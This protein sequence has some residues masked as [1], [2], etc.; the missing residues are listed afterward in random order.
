MRMLMHVIPAV[1]KFN[2]A[3]RKGSAGATMNKILETIKPEAT[4]FTEA[5]GRRSV[6]MI[7]DLADPSK[8]P[9]LAEP[10]FL[11]FN[12]EVRFQVVMMPQDLQRAGLD[13]LGKKWG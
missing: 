12:A 2:E 4:Y 1:E 6:L 11:A 10:W 13:D 7:V 5:D 8:V 9:A 3:V